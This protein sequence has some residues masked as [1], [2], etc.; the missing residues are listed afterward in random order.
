M[1]F[2]QPLSLEAVTK[3]NLR[4]VDGVFDELETYSLAVDGVRRRADAAHAFVSTRPPG[5]EPQRKHV[6]LARSGTRAVGLLDLI[7]G[8]PS[9]GTVFIGLL[10]IRG[11]AQGAG[12]GR[13]LY[14]EAE[15]FARADLGARV[16]RL[17]VVKT[18]PVVGFWTRMGFHMTGAIKPFQG[19]RVMSQAMVMEKDL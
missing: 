8:Y 10:A 9:A 4:D 5:C 12:L 15:R 17:A 3:Q 6:F 14:G 2:G 16:L 19:E 18:N 11:S 7:D 13:A 1:G